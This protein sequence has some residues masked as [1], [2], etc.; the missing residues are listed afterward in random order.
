MKDENKNL[1]RNKHSLVTE[2]KS[3][4]TTPTLKYQY[5]GMIENGEGRLKGKLDHRLE[6]IITL[7][8]TLGRSF[9]NIKRV[10]TKN[11]LSI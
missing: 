11:E 1:G 4:N 7:F 8:Q 10:L 6:N 5:L 9:L 3:K 2:F